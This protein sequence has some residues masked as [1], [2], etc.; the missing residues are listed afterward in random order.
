MVLRNLLRPTLTPPNEH[1]LVV[2]RETAHTAIPRC[3]S[4]GGE[5]RRRD[6]DGHVGAA[7]GVGE[8]VRGP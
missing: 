8:K 4:D 3:L 5:S 1:C 6:G 7:L 2:G